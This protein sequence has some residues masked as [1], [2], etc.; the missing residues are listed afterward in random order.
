MKIDDTI[1][2]EYILKLLNSGG[3][4]GLMKIAPEVCCD[5]DRH[6]IDFHLQEDIISVRADLEKKLKELQVKQR[7]LTGEIQIVNK[8]LE[9]I[10]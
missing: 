6:L 4:N 10:R 2:L 9:E 8:Q 5:W 7:E 1:R 3:T